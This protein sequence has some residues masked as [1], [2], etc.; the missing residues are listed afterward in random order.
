MIWALKIDI[1]VFE[2]I[3][4]T[5][6]KKKWPASYRAGVTTKQNNSIPGGSAP[7]PLVLTKQ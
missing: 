6:R 5:D 3:K 2:G 1:L 7:Y 4:E